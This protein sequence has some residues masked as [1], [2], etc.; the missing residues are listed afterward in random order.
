MATNFKTI[1][2]SKEEAL[3]FLNGNEPTREDIIN[4][5]KELDKYIYFTFIYDEV[6]YLYCEN[7]GRP[8]IDLVQ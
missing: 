4:I 6:R 3:E 2:R 1:T 7:N 8:S 5:F